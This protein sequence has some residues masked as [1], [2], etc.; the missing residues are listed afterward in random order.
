MRYLFSI[1]TFGFGLL[2]GSSREVALAWFPGPEASAEKSV[3]GNI[4]KFSGK[5]QF[6]SALIKDEMQSLPLRIGNSI[7][8]ENQLTHPDVSG[9]ATFAKSEI[10][11]VDLKA[12]VAFY[13]RRPPNGAQEYVSTQVELRKADNRLVALCSYYELPVNS[14]PLVTGAC[15]GRDG[16]HLLGLT[17]SK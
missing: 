3:N 2:L 14:V 9:S 4:L 17:L 10:S 1:F 6:W 13:W 8:V 11:I 7:A 5:A 12:T 15:S 16:D